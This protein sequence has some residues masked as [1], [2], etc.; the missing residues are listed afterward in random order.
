MG[1]LIC[2]GIEYEVLGIWFIVAFVLF[3]T[4]Y[5]GEDTRAAWYQV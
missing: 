2:L 4:R 1:L 3:V 5:M